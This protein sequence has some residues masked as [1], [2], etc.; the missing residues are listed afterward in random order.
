M[1]LIDNPAETH[2][3]RNIMPELNPTGVKPKRPDTSEMLKEVEKDP[4]LKRKA[5]EATKKL[6]EE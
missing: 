3:V 6:S 2:S 4:R 1:L 5:I